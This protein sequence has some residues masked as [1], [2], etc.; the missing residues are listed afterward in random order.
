MSF[1]HMYFLISVIVNILY[2]KGEFK[3]VESRGV[4]GKTVGD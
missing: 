4:I 3:L 1:G 2:R